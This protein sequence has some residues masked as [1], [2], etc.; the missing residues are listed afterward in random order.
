MFQSL[1]GFQVRCNTKV[2]VDCVGY[3]M[4]QSLS[5][6]QVRCNITVIDAGGADVYTFQSLSGFQVRCNIATGRIGAIDYMRFNPC[7]VFKCAATAGQKWSF[8]PKNLSKSPK[9]NP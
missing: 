1:S 8:Y 2:Q 6:F 7:R 5:G 4:F 9:I 3:S